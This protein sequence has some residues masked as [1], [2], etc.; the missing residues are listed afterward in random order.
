MEQ[1]GDAYLTLRGL[2]ADLP[3]W[4]IVKAQQATFVTRGENIS[5]PTS[6]ADLPG[7]VRSERGA[8]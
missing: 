6:P 1:I 8:S 4:R 5:H 3:P 2:A 7:A